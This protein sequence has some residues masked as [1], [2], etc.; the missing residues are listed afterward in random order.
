MCIC[1]PICF[2]NRDYKTNSFTLQQF[3][4]D[5][6]EKKHYQWFM[7]NFQLFS[8]VALLI[9]PKFVLLLT[10]IYRVFF[11]L[12]IAVTQ[13]KHQK[14]LFPSER[15]IL[16]SN[17]RTRDNLSKRE[18]PVQNGSVGTYVRSKFLSIPPKKIR[19]PVVFW[20]LFGY[21]K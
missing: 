10:W 3:H 7:T 6:R 20:L 2:Y 5:G 13:L 15:E 4:L 12:P 21:R 1:L 11:A 8:Q 14:T 18:S 19:T 9:E 16:R 17:G